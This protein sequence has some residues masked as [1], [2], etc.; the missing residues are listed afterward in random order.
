MNLSR[1]QLTFL[2]A[3]MQEL[4]INAKQEADVTSTNISRTNLVIY[5]S[6][7]IGFLLLM[8]IFANFFM[9]NI[10]I[11]HSLHSMKGINSQVVML[12]T[13]IDGITSSVEDM[14]YSVENL[15]FMEESVERIAKKTHVISRYIS[16][17]NTQTTQLSADTGYVRYFAAKIDQ[18]FGRI[19]HSVGQVSYSLRET[20]KPIRQFIP[21]P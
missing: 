19:N 2:H 21:L 15:Q 6:S 13:S 3:H 5:I 18:R 14:G 17:I 1:K 20:S 8:L 10:A 9:L 7:A 4:A 11:G 16:E 12:R